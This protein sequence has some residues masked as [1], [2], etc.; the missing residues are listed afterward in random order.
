MTK[1][2]NPIFESNE[3]DHNCLHAF[4]ANSVVHYP[5]NGCYAETDGE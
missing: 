4:F 1:F 2:V 5:R 3:N